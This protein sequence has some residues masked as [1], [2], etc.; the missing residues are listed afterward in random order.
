MSAKMDTVNSLMGTIASKDDEKF[1]SYLTDDIVYHYHVGSRPLEGKDWVRRFL[2]KYWQIT[3]N[4]KWRI[5]RH[6]E[7]E[8]A[9]LVEGEEEYLDTRTDEIV[10]HPYMGAFDFRDGLISGWRDYFEMAPDKS[11]A[12]LAVLDRFM[13]S[14]NQADADAMRG[15]YADD[16]RIWH[17]FEDKLQTV[18]ENVQSMLWMHTKLTDLN[19]EIVS[20]KPFP[21]GI[22]QQH[23]LQGTLGSGKPFKLHACAIVT[24][25]DDKIV[26]EEFYYGMG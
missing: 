4:V 23:L 15:V 3:A 10:S 22:V 7:T 5:D 6:A 1:L 26:R 18:E 9:L 17:N 11:G 19:Y 8:D 21:A 16:A 24:V 12:A 13:D 14:L 25:K 2:T 20:R